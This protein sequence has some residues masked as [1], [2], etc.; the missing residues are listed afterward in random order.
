MTKISCIIVDDEPL[1]VEMLSVY[2]QRTETL[3]L[4]STF[5][6]SVQAFSV[7]SQQKP[8]LVFM[9]IQMPDL[10]G[11]ELSRLLP[12]DT[13]VIF[14]TAFKQ[15]AYDSY[16]VEAVDYLLKPIS[17]Q[18]FLEAVAKA[19]KWFQVSRASGSDSRERRSAFIKVD[20]GYRNI[21]FD[22]IAY[23]SGMKDYV[24]IHLD[25]DPTPLITHMTLRTVEDMLPSEMFMRVHRSHIVA[26]DKIM[27]IDSFGDIMLAGSTVPVS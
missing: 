5:T 4:L 6:D 13:R 1:A 14:T 17:Y 16:Q 7:I 27:S 25:S 21:Y 11:M 10:N 8:D 9:D 26:L 15:F 18:K 2:V 12:E 23:V 3:Q 24:M 22:D 19:E 20:G